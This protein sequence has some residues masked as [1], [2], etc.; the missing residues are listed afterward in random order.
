M[1]WSA[2]HTN[3]ATCLHTGASWYT[4]AVIPGKDAGAAAHTLCLVAGQ[5]HFKSCP[6]RL[7]FAWPPG[8]RTIPSS[9]GRP[10]TSTSLQTPTHLPKPLKH[11]G[12]AQTQEGT[13]YCETALLSLVS[14][15][16]VSQAPWPHVKTSVGL[17][18]VA[19]QRPTSHVTKHLRATAE[20]TCMCTS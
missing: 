18:A 15:Q 14:K 9:K 12:Q 7:E 10:T 19:P 2:G 6:R 17:C 13:R 1:P 4:L 16:R 3:A 5:T 11:S 20:S 8:A